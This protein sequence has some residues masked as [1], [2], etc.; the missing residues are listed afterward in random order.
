MS[1]GCVLRTENAAVA[2]GASLLRRV[3]FGVVHC[4]DDDDL[5]QAVGRRRRRPQL[6]HQGVKRVRVDGLLLVGLKGHLLA[7]VDRRVNGLRLEVLD[8]S[9]SSGGDVDCI[10]GGR[11]QR[12]GFGVGGGGLRVEGLTFGDGS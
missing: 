4:P 8:F 6:L 10:A 5:L 7:G 2:A 11:R 12:C 1:T 3:V 9:R